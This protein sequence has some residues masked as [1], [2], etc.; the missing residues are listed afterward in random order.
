MGFIGNLVSRIR[1]SGDPR[2]AFKQLR[3]PTDPLAVWLSRTSDNMS[4]EGLIALCASLLEISLIRDLPRIPPSV[5]GM[6]DSD[7]RL[8]LAAAVGAALSLS[9]GQDQVLEEH[10][11]GFHEMWCHEIYCYVMASSAGKPNVFRI[12]EDLTENLLKTDLVGVS[13]SDVQIPFAGLYLSIGASD[14]REI[15]GA[16]A[17]SVTQ[18]HDERGRRIIHAC[19]HSNARWGHV[20]VDLSGPFPLSSD[21]S[22]LDQL[23]KFIVNALL[24]I[25]SPNPDVMPAS[26][27][28]VDT[29]WDEAV[30]AAR[31]SPR[32]PGRHKPGARMLW[33]VGASVKRLRV[34][35]LD[36]LVRGHWRRQAHGPRH[37][38]RKMIWV[39]PH[40]RMPT[41]AP[42][43]GHDYVVDE[44]PT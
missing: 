15:S 29:A 24:Y 40:I 19:A 25:T 17:V 20:P 2:L 42:T 41:G 5:V 38:L 31:T 34:A 1:E 13:S 16:S 35:A 33:N 3:M 32:A 8:A 18:S 30:T 14:I 27:A 7:R 44:V 6:G 28:R 39:Q 11:A 12:S 9:P 36:V 26:G 10:C 43:A 4:A 37:S 22:D 23:G 21:G